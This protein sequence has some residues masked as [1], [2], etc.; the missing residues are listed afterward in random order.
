M[1]H[2]LFGATARCR[3]GFL[4]YAGGT[5]PLSDF[6]RAYV[7]LQMYALSNLTERKVEGIHAVIKRLGSS[8]T[9]V[10]V[11]YICARLREDRNIA[12]L[13]SDPEFFDFCQTTWRKR[14]LYD[15]VLRQ[16]FTPEELQGM[17]N[18]EKLKRIYQ[19]T[20]SDEFEDMTEARRASHDAM[21]LTLVQRVGPEPS[22]NDAWKCA[23]TYLRG[24]FHLNVVYSVPQEIWNMI[25]GN[26]RSDHMQLLMADPIQAAMDAVCARAPRLTSEALPGL[27]FFQVKQV[28]P[29]KRARVG[30][31]HAPPLRYGIHVCVCSVSDIEHGPLGP[32]AVVLSSEGGSIVGV[33]LIAMAS[34]I[35]AVMDSM[36]TWRVVDQRANR[37]L[38]D[39]PHQRLHIHA[40]DIVDVPSGP[41][42]LAVVARHTD[43]ASVERLISELAAMGAWEGR[44]A[45]PADSTTAHIDTVLALRDAGAIVAVADEFGGLQIALSPEAVQ[46][47]V[48]LVVSFARRCGEPV[49]NQPVL[50]RPKLDLLLQLH[51]EGWH[52][53]AHAGPLAPWA[54]GSMPN[55]LPRISK[56]Q[57][58]FAAIVSRWDILAKRVTTTRHDGKD[59][60]YRALVRLPSE[61]LL[62]LLDRMPDDAP[63]LPEETFKQALR[64]SGEGSDQGS[65][66]GS[67]GS[68]TEEEPRPIAD[69]DPSIAP[70]IFSQAPTWERTLVD[71]G[72]GTPRIKVYFTG[73]DDRDKGRG[74]C[75]CPVTD[76][77]K[78]MF[79]HL[80]RDRDHFCSHM[81]TWYML[82]LE[83][84]GLDRSRH[85]LE[86]VDE[87]VVEGMLPT[88][89]FI[90]F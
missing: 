68:G 75:P 73:V 59:A 78:W 8:M 58:Y 55:F 13:R 11:P 52:A 83:I 82:A 72:E 38:L 63:A 4:E 24:T 35:K 81:Y 69:I 80:A 29:E 3:P 28:N 62:A 84:P 44:G 77:C 66:P 70:S 56:P 26:R 47:S 7:A 89:R 71:A 79:T 64:E 54:D 43:T 23:V 1:S 57:S 30:V 17:S 67:G 10:T 21:N 18:N 31:F 15:T 65:D 87:A 34:T 32:R 33:D 12:R 86:D 61:T 42:E 74:F 36:H 88:L 85:L 46:W 19:C 51:S 5:R 2:V 6:P 90:P 9:F 22:V 76:C 49:L 14:S 20:L 53:P 27:V 16:R 39:A 41:G 50:H 60:Y 40:P 45:A 48:R 25:Y 37:R